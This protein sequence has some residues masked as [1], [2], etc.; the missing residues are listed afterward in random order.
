MTGIRRVHIAIRGAVQ[1][2]GFRPF[3]Y[4]LANELRLTGW[5]L[6]SP[7]G[8]FV[9]AEGSTGHHRAIPA[10]GS[11]RKNLPAPLSKAWNPTSFDPAGFTSFEIRASDPRGE[12]TALVL[13]DIATCPDCLCGHPRPVEPP[14]QISVHQ[15]HELRPPLHDHHCPSLRPAEHF[16]E[17]V[18]HVRPV[19]GRV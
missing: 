16:H 1:G 6:N 12:R 2:V 7:Q 17:R 4:R 18:R 15:L 19:P 3:I 13:P 5:V 10:C 11:S 14:L 9:E 8:V